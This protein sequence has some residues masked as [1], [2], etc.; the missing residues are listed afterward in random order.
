MQEVLSQKSVLHC[1]AQGGVRSND[2]A[3]FN[4][5]Q[6]SQG[7][8]QK[9]EVEY[10]SQD[11]TTNFLSANLTSSAKSLSIILYRGSISL[12]HSSEVGQKGWNWFPS[13]CTKIYVEDEIIQV[14]FVTFVK[15]R[16]L[17]VLV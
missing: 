15:D 5:E 9:E 10:Q 3:H 7:T 8:A 4:S 17:I 1:S 16:F 13:F 6:S 14:T 2:M 12:S 11:C